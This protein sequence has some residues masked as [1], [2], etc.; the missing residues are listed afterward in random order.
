MSINSRLEIDIQLSLRRSLGAI[1][2]SPASLSLPHPFY[3]T[4][5]LTST[6]TSLSP[7]DVQKQLAMNETLDFLK[8]VWLSRQFRKTIP[9]PL[10]RNPSTAYPSS[11]SSFRVTCDADLF[12]LF[13]TTGELKHWKGLWVI[14][15]YYS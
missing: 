9:L 6:S 11:P 7:Q 2:N 15:S 1:K 3:T 4:Q 10:I 12:F 13:P 14:Q 8:V 5:A